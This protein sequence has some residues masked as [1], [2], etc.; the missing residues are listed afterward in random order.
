[1][2]QFRGNTSTTRGGFDRTGATNNQCDGSNA[3]R[4][5]GDRRYC[6]LRQLLSPRLSLRL[7]NSCLMGQAKYLTTPRA[8]C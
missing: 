1:M 4:C 5:E 7:T 2:T 6:Y 3:G 8:A